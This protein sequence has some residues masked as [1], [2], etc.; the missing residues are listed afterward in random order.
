M[1]GIMHS[2]SNEPLPALKLLLSQTRNQ[3]EPAHSRYK[4]SEV[5]E[6]AYLVGLE[7][8]LSYILGNSFFLSFFADSNYNL[9]AV[10][11]TLALCCNEVYIS[12]GFPI[13]KNVFGIIYV[14][15]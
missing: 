12:S 5:Q 6:G 7:K 10:Q 8:K 14:I 4:L 15:F 2:L 3:A 11:N 1:V 13:F 9:F